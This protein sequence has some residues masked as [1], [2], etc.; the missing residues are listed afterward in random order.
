MCEIRR[1]LVRLTSWNWAR[2]GLSRLQ[3]LVFRQGVEARAGLHGVE[4]IVANNHGVGELSM[5][6]FKKGTHGAF[7][8]LGAGVGRATI[9]IQA[10]FVADAY[11]V[12]VVVLA[13]CAN[14]RQWTT[15]FY[16]SVTT[17]HIVVAA[18]FPAT[19]TVPA[20]NLADSA[21]LPRLHSRAMND[22]V[23]DDTHGR[24]F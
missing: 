21:L 4:H 9:D 24:C 20:A 16:R 7:L 2:L 19:G 17:N 13:M 15:D 1:D 14:L 11:R 6:L 23:V 8:R 18:A 12:A 5:K 10:A 3:V 22:D